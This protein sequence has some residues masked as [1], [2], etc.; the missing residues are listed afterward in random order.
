ERIKRQRLRRERS[1]AAVGAERGDAHVDA[2][3]L[4]LLSLLSR[5]TGF[6]LSSATEVRLLVDGGRTY[7]HLLAAFARARHHIHLE[8]YIFE[9]DRTG[10]MIRDALVERARTG[11]RVRLLVDAVGAYRLGERFLGPLREAGA[12]IARFHPFRLARIL[13]PSVN[14]RSHR[15]I[16]VVDGT[17]AFT[18]GINICDENNERRNAHAYHDLHL[19]LTGEVVRWLQVAFLEDWHYATGQLVREPQLWPEALPGP[20]KAMVVPSGPDSALEPMHRTFVEL[21]NSA[22]ARVWLVTPYF[23]PSE[24]ALMALTSAAMKGLDVRL[25]LPKRSDSLVATA[26]A[27]S[28]Y[29][30]LLA[31]GVQVFEYRDR[32]VHSKALLVDEDRA[33]VGSANF[34]HRSFFLN[35]EIAVLFLDAGVAADLERL[36]EA[37]CGA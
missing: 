12:E 2:T 17:I 1:R 30:V 37:D 13:R 14:L 6:P 20:V 31:A 19:R 5:V 18:G 32:M 22:R 35:F 34:D 4:P 29:D 9:P 33:L 36:I 3:D 16:V 24:A 8:Y 28:W 23:A 10:A 11:V 25:L 26:V 21:I 15:K 27:R 7:D